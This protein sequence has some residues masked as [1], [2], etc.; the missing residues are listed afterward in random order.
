[1]SRMLPVTDIRTPV[2]SVTNHLVNKCH[3]MG[4]WE[5]YRISSAPRSL[6]LPYQ[7]PLEGSG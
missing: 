1:M 7:D 6:Q 2:G 5:T 4:S 3:V